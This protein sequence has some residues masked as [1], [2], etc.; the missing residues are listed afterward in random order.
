MEMLLNLVVGKGK[1]LLVV[2]HD[3]ALAARGGRRLEMI[4]GCLA[5][6]TIVSPSPGPADAISHV[7][8][9]SPSPAAPSLPQP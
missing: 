7:S 2:T 9:L 1:A 8:E 4:N 6:N 5:T 3:P